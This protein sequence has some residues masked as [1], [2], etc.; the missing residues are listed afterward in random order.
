[1]AE[2][3]RDRSCSEPSNCLLDTV[4][5]LW[6][7]ILSWSLMGVDKRD[8][9]A[10]KLA[11]IELTIFFFW[12]QVLF[13]IKNFMVLHFWKYLCFF[14]GKFLYFVETKVSLFKVHSGKSLH[15]TWQWLEQ[16]ILYFCQYFVLIIKMKIMK[17]YFVELIGSDFKWLW[18]TFAGAFC[19]LLVYITSP[20]TENKRSQT[21]SCYLQMPTCSLVCQ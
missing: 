5:I 1:M 16:L 3:A 9:W 8:N 11:V 14:L 10:K 13:C 17:I 19:R 6:G 4:L 20:Q 21:S 2:K 18:T 7:E 15:P 12:F